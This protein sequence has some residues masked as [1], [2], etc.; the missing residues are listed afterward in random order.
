MSILGTI[1]GLVLIGLIIKA[2]FETFW[3][4]CLIINGLFWH[5]VAFVLDG[6]ALIAR[7]FA[8]LKKTANW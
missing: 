7:G 6:F 2:L 5:A 8:K 4:I 3:G 1:L